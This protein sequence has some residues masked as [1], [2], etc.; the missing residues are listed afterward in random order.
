MMYNE[1]NRL[2]EKWTKIIYIIAVNV[3]LPAMMLPKFFISFFGYFATDMGNAAFEL[4]F[5]VL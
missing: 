2:I 4:P 1:T 3:V 5:P